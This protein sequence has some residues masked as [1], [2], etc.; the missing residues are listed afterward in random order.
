MTIIDGLKSY[1]QYFLNG[2]LENK[3]RDFKGNEFIKD[4]TSNAK[5]IIPQNNFE[6]EQYIT[7]ASCGQG[8]WS[9]VPWLAIF[10]K[11]ITKSATKGLFILFF[12]I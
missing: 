11:S 8:V 10:D 5:N 4:I 7:K 1:L 3:S 9:E 12:L 2:Y 6:R